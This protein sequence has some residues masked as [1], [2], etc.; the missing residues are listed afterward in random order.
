[1]PTFAYEALNS[2]GK[3]QK[4]TIE[5]ASSEEAIQR[6]KSQ[7][8]FPTSVREQKVKSEGK[9]GRRPRART[10]KKAEEGRSTLHR[11]VSQK[12]L[13]QFTRQLS[14]LQDAGL[15]LLRS[16][17]ILESSRSRACSSHPRAGR[18]GRGGRLDAVRRDGRSTPRR[19]TACT[20]D[21]QRRRDRRRARH[22]P[23]ASGEFM[24][25]AQRLKRRIIGAMIY[26]IAV[27][28]IAVLI[29]TGIMYFVIPKFQEIF[30]DFEV[31][32]PGLTVWLTQRQSRGWRAI[33]KDQVG[34]GRGV[35]HRLAVR[36]L[37]PPEADPQDRSRPG[38]HGHIR[39]RMPVSARSSEDVDRPLHADAG[40]AD[41][42]GRADS[43][44]DPHHPR[45]LGQ[46]RLREGPDAGARL[47]PRGRVVRRPAARGQG[48][49]TRSW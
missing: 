11:R 14:T 2:A 41:L 45:H 38:D 10:K 19:S 49:A 30:N 6:I 13:T 26:P 25:K 27:I 23:P 31:A 33:S 15:P 34:A 46:L 29:V 20:E 5:A 36:G 37:D 48:R 40:H 17:Q 18:R 7:G 1:M 21:D 4:G 42:G 32:L 47:D 3:E 35:D 16:L 43:R 24:E 44:G 12:K 9:P 22:H 28:T 39:V 8:Y